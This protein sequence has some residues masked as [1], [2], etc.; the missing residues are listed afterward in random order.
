[1]N[2]YW[3]RDKAFIDGARKTVPAADI[4]PSAA[5]PAETR[6]VPAGAEVPVSRQPRVLVKKPGENIWFVRF[7]I[8]DN[9]EEVGYEIRLVYDGGKVGPV[10]L[11]RE[12][13]GI[14]VWKDRRTVAPNVRSH[15]T[16][17]DVSASVTVLLDELRKSY[18]N[19]MK[20]LDKS[21]SKAQWDS[22]WADLC[23]TH[24]MTPRRAAE[25]VRGVA[26]WISVIKREL[27]RRGTTMPSYMFLLISD[28]RP[29][30]EVYSMTE[31]LPDLPKILMYADQMQAVA[32]DE[33]I[34]AGSPAKFDNWGHRPMLNLR[35]LLDDWQRYQ[36]DGDAVLYLREMAKIRNGM[37]DNAVRT[38]GVE[39]SIGKFSVDDMVGRLLEGRRKGEVV[40]APSGVDKV[41][42]A[43]RGGF[44][45]QYMIT[46]GL[47]LDECEKILP[48]L[49]AMR[50][51]LDRT[52][53]SYEAMS[54]DELLN[55]PDA[56][57]SGLYPSF[58]A[59]AVMSYKREH[60][61]T[62]RQVLNTEVA[63][64]LKQ[65]LVLDRM[66][67]TLRVMAAMTNPGM[68]LK[69][70]ARK[71]IP[72]DEFTKQLAYLEN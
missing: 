52:F 59:T 23:S 47:T 29:Y 42:D 3:Q 6:V 8:I 60:S 58:Y 15:V 33:W 16:P 50:P 2:G 46:Q 1:M 67:K 72:F 14:D 55:D 65:G 30:K 43:T 61:L 32:V 38:M 66:F 18:P 40:R 44:F 21:I 5:V 10:A 12:I 28:V 62:E 48:L 24:R 9:G 69:E 7:P 57:N 31:V 22:I 4:K 56:K 27:D 37:F 26:S 71:G 39:D 45:Y 34:M 17:K 53:G 13:Y 64:G 11:T 68:S 49:Q 70:A 19:E 51:V 20:E 25:H 63:R 54:V 36:A 41:Y 35:G